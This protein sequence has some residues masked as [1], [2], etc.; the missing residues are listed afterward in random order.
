[1]IYL[2]SI[3][4]WLALDQLTKWLITSNFQL[5]QSQVVIE[6]I[7]SITYTTNTGAAFGI[8]PTHS[9][10]FMILK[11]L[12]LLSGIVMIKQVVKLSPSYQ[13][14]AGTILGGAAGNLVDRIRLG[15]VIDFINFHFWPTFNVADI[16]ICVGV[17]L[18]VIQLFREKPLLKADE[19]TVE[20]ETFGISLKQEKGE[21]MES[22]EE[23][24]H[25][26]RNDE[27][28]HII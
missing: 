12:F 15:S 11:M 27:P 5:H 19:I 22:D 9:G 13:L 3:I 21:S 26:E 17:F 20:N 24:I 2:I 10:F 14:A 1:M 7:L 8:F 18:L 23:F 4:T 25:D 16:A 28:K 6:N